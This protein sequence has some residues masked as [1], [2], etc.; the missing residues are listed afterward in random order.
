MTPR[1]DALRVPPHS[2]D[3][4]QNVLGGL[5]ISTN[6]LAKVVD[7]ISE[8]DFYRKDHRLIFRAI[9]EL[10]AR[11]TPYDA[12]TLA[13]WFHENK[14]I[15]LV[16][17]MDYVLQ[18][19]NNTASAA[20]I[21]AYANIVR[22]KSLLRQV[23][24][25]GCE[26]TQAGF[27]PS[28]KSA[29]A[30]LDETISR[31]MAMHRVEQQAE[32][33]AKQAAKKAYD[34]MTA[35]HAN[36]GALD[37]VPTG[38]LDVD[39]K[40]GGLHPGDLIVIGARAAMGKTSLL[41]GMALHAAEKAHP[42]GMIS[43]EQPVEQIASRMMALRGNVRATKFR[44]GQ[45]TDDEWPRVTDAFLAVSRAPIWFLDRSSPS[46]VECQ[47]VA[48]RWKQQHG[49]KALYVDY[50][51]RLDAPGERRWE[52]VG[53]AVKGLKDLA[54]ELNIPV[55]VLAQVSRQ[56]ETGGKGREPRLG[57]LS[58]SSEIEKEADQVLMIYREEYY[59]PDTDRPGVAKIIIEK[60]RHGPTGY[61]EVAWQAETMR[62]AN[63]SDAA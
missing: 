6:A 49:I 25:I 16:G 41:T 63:L 59:K 37:T 4:E 27:E 54:R 22:E 18:V 42:V 29:T 39:S 34:V 56:V 38:L 35:A 58:D 53:N 32:F 9:T 12:V 55:I 28:G 1:L 11:N 3:A 50:L 43:G 23:I 14:L 33:S 24:D 10:D 45:F 13:E 61:V 46:I 31:L 7:V 62:F 52:S 44:T 40:L 47:R 57:D 21:L 8:D 19:A 30:M 20:N 26:L 51:Q 48:R 2:Q 15:E 60:N 36:N 17:G 5:M